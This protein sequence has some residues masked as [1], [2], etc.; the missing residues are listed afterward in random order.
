MSALCLVT[1]GGGQVGTALR[2]IAPP[3]DISLK[4]LGH[5]QLDIGDGQAVED[6]FEA[7]RPGVVIN[8]AAFTDVD[9]AE[10]NADA[11]YRTNRD[12]PAILAHA[13]AEA[14]I[15]LIHLS[16]DYVFGMPGNPPYTEQSPVTPQGVYAISKAAGEAAV[17]DGLD[18]HIIV[19]TSWV[20][21]ARPGNF[22]SSILQAGRHR[23]ELSVVA[24]Q[25]G[26]PTPAA[27]LAASLMRMAEAAIG[28]DAPWGTYHTCG[29]PAVTRFDWARA[30]FDLA[31]PGLDCVPRLIPVAA[32]DYPAEAPRPA[33]SALDC[34]RILNAFGIKQ[35][36]WRA[37]LALVVEKLL[38]E[39]A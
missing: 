15:P 3:S 27:D 12:G 23:D 8:A 26:C 2:E 1:G 14:A 30:L 29:T 28:R 22:V 19:R 37:G 16:T 39:S 18:K 36:D 33:N 5:R 9:G 24:D 25:T 10:S 21:S 17:R 35:P 20:F 32:A 6:A 38:G 13:C 4:F 34:A 11:A 7:H 31:A